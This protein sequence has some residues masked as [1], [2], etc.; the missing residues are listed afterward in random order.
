MTAGDYFGEIAALTGA[1]RTADVVAEE[2]T[3]LLQVPTPILRVM[4]AQPAFSRMLLTRMSER[5]ARTSIRELPRTVG[6]DPQDARELQE[7]P[8]MEL[9]QAPAPG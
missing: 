9:R 1:A 4:M 5:L 8:A 2:T 3:Q 7:G 6:I